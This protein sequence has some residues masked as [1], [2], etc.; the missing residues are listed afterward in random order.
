MPGVLTDHPQH[1][2]APNYFALGTH[3]L[4]RRSDFHDHLQCL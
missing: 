3:F 4:H 1:A 2:V